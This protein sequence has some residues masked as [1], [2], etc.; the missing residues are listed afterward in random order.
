MNIFSTFPE[1][2]I[3]ESPFNTTNGCATN[4]DS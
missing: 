4:F 1:G 3:A 2:V